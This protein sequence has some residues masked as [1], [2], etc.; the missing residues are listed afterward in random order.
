MKK[1]IYIIAV[2]ISVVATTTLAAATPS[3]P[4]P[5]A[6][7]PT[8]SI[9]T[10]DDD[11]EEADSTVKTRRNT[12]KEFNALKYIMEGRYRNY[13]DEFTKAWDDHL[14][15]EIGA[16]LQ[17]LVPPTASYRFSP[18]TNVHIGVGKQFSPLHTA[19][20]SLSGAYGYQRIRNLTFTR[21]GLQADWI[22][23]VSS[24]F[25]GYNPSR[26]LDV[27]TVLGLGA[28]YTS[29]DGAGKSMLAAEAHAGLQL[30]FFSGPQGY[31]VLEPSIGVASDNID[32]SEKR[33][34]RK[35]DIFYG[36]NISFVY[37]L[38]NN[39]S[40]EERIRFMKHH[41]AE[42]DSTMPA[43]WRTPWF[44]QV[45]GGPALISSETLGTGE[46][47]G[48]SAT[49]SVGKWLSPA[50][51]IRASASLATTTW[52][53][54]VSPAREDVNPEYINNQHNHNADFRLEAIINP[55]GFLKNFKWES[56]YGIYL[57][58]GGGLGW[59][60]KNQTE[61]L[62]CKSTFYTLGL[63][64]WA[65]L[66]KDIQV[67]IEPRY[68]Y[69]NYK[70]PYS[71]VSWARKYSDD[72]FGLNIGLSISNRSHEYRH[73]VSGE[74]EAEAEKPH[75]IFGLGIGG[76]MNLVHTKSSYGR[77]GLGYNALSMMEYHINTISAARLSFEY[78]SISPNS[79]ES[80]NDIN[81]ALSD[82][83][84][85]VGNKLWN[86]R[87]NMG[88]IALNY[89]V[90]ASNALAGFDSRR[91]E[92]EAFGGPAFMLMLN[93][94]AELD[95]SEITTEG[96][97]YIPVQSD[98]TKSMFGVNLGVKL[99]FNVTNSLSVTFTPQVYIFKGDNK[100]PGLN[101]TKANTI[102]TLNIGVQYNLSK[103]KKTKKRK[104]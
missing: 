81:T 49:F 17:K 87:Y 72:G 97:T 8:D 33:N 82:Q 35:K 94:K 46:T 32:Q 86:R 13:G 100:L 3:Y 37:Y 73:F 52:K 26:M 12:A 10:D 20:M 18:M 25:G 45:A 93:N 47:L 101:F 84:P 83:E 23:S 85:T 6:S 69:Y 9:S 55:F 59:L 74:A 67:F 95:A 28:Q 63:H 2:L 79:L 36:A 103:I 38:H 61:L 75:L 4:L 11:E 24:Y 51:A 104:K 60:Q 70:I 77:N 41:I 39:L 30:R 50:I 53:K 44:F 57:V 5:A 62:R 65:R 76:G 43:Q 22:F 71:N 102:E 16:G 48:H 40:P 42:S 66:E 58:G 31:L 15:I 92:I 29:K 14:F 89:M 99:M 80:A 54:D 19:R 64:L 88:L 68:T 98:V 34:W 27:S 21:I 78:M 56:P 90:N 96:H 91:F 7:L 1:Q